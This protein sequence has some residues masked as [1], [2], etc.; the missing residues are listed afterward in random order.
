MVEEFADDPNAWLW[1]FLTGLEAMLTNRVR[2]GL[3][4]GP[5]EWW[6]AHCSQETVKETGLSK[7]WVCYA[8]GTA[9]KLK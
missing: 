8:A 6:G 7:I 3:V 2:E 5:S 9:D 1:D 4:V